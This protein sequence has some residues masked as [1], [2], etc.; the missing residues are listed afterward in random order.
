[1]MLREKSSTHPKVQN[2]MIRTKSI[3]QP[4]EED[5]GIRILITRFYPRGV[6]KDH[7]DYWIRELAP[8]QSLL[9][10]Y[11]EGERNWN[12][13]KIV[14]LAELRENIESLEI[15]H[16]LNQHIANDNVTLLCYEK[17]GT[18]CHRHMVRDIVENPLLLESHFIPENTN[19]HETIPIQ[20]HV[21]NQK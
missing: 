18:P 11:K 2:I 16:A 17:D 19:D 1:M 7:F 4:R 15:I 3:Y 12:D 13:F 8:S 9:K 5:D 21:T 6:K 20:I 14:F 10:S